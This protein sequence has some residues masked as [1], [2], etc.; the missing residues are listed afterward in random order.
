MSGY[1]ALR[2]SAAWADISSRGRIQVT[3]E[4]RVQFV[5][6]MCSNDVQSLRPG[7]GIRAFFLDVQGHIQADTRIFVSED[8]VLIDCEPERSA[9][10]RE[11]LE[12][13]IV[14]EDVTLL[15]HSSP[16]VAIEGP[17]ADKV[18]H[19]VFNIAPPPPQPYSHVHE[20]GLTTIRTSLTG[21]PGLWLIADGGSADGGSADGGSNDDERDD[22]ENNSDL[23]AKLRAAGVAAATAEDV[24]TV[25]AENEVPRQGDDFTDSTLPNHIEQA[26]AISFTKGC[27]LGQEIV[28]RVRS[29]GRINRLLV[30]VEIETT[31]LPDPGAVVLWEEKDVGRLTSPVF[32]P[33]M[34]RVMAFAILRREAASPGTEFTVN[35]RRGRV[36]SRNT[37]RERLER[38]VLVGS[39]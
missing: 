30:G 19:Q 24:L 9:R 1:F 6:A 38:E 29:R 25:R 18:A 3:G 10:L 11:H 4:D 31:E 32:S 17:G 34:E 28:E 7:Q 14:M 35:G 15:R 12:R 16:A 2:E 13:F 33:T 23:A 39:E 20:G 21:Q 5:H 27:Y 36:R 37:D 8:H 22:G 26:E